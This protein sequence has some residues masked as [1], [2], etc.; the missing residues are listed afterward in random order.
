MTGLR[1]PHAQPPEQLRYAAWLEWGT[2]AGLAVL[3]V[4]FAAYVFGLLP[5]LV[6]PPEPRERADVTLGDGQDVRGVW[7][8]RGVHD[9]RNL[10]LVKR[11]V[12]AAK[13]QAQARS[14]S[15]GW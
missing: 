12:T 7:I 15:R 14:M 8:E 6:P 11:D 10:G 3:V 13:K 2:R 1:A 9:R 4:S 5:S